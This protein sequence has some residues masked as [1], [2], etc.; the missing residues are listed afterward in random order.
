LCSPHAA[1]TWS[2]PTVAKE[3][4][5]KVEERILRE[6]VK[7]GMSREEAERTLLADLE[8]AAEEDGYDGP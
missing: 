2:F 5:N 8:E 1:F 3:Q 7:S 6:W 4:W